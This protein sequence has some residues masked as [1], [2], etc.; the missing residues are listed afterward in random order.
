MRFELLGVLAALGLAFGFPVQEGP[1]DTDARCVGRYGTDMDGV[2]SSYKL[3][4]DDGLANDRYGQAVGIGEHYAVVGAPNKATP[5]DHC[6]GVVYIYRR[7]LDSWVLDG[8]IESPNPETGFFFG[9]SVAVYQSTIVIGKSR[10]SLKQ[11][12][13]SVYERDSTGTWVETA[14][15]TADDGAE[16]DRF[17]ISVS[18]DGDV[19]VIGAFGDDAE[20]A[21]NAG[22]AYVYEKASN[23]WS[24]SA[25][26][27]PSTTAQG[28]FGK[29]VDISGTTVL[30][31]APGLDN[32]G[33]AFFYS[34]AG[35]TWSL[36]E[37]VLAADGASGDKFGESVAVDDATA[38]IGA[39]GVSSG[40]G[41]AYVFRGTT[42]RILRGRNLGYLSWT[43]TSKLVAGDQDQMDLF[44]NVVDIH[45]S[46]IAVGAMYASPDGWCSGGA[47]LF[48]NTVGEIWVQTRMSA[49][50][51]TQ[52]DYLGISVAL[53]GNYMIAG[54]TGDDDMGS[55]S[56]SAYIYS[57]ATTIQGSC[58]AK[59]TQTQGGWFGAKKCRG[60]N[61][62]CYLLENFASAF[63]NGLVIGSSTRFAT[64]ATVEELW[65]LSKGGDAD[66]LPSSCDGGC[67]VAALSKKNNLITQTVALS[68]NVGFDSCSRGDCVSFCENCSGY[69]NPLLSAHVL[70]DMG[71]CTGMS[72]GQVLAEANCVLG[73]GSDCQEGI[74]DCIDYINNNYVDGLG[75]D[76]QGLSC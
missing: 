57:V 75:A 29:D 38:V 39:P 35:G 50:D 61:A 3:L 14:L 30:V 25:Q 6:Q 22:S 33:A 26:L 41:A 47:Y 11:G 18:I 1:L 13:A 74:I 21:S 36:V 51:N 60:N 67:T 66:S 68:L 72:V 52:R 76:A 54:A 27:A 59:R 42:S 56:G 20:G 69:N 10:A 58:L 24:L 64:I 62:A 49:A 32:K 73:G 5:A 28:H 34:K 7:V 4:A 31:G 2:L 55:H 65:Q 16:G 70:N 45:D 48:Q 17:G 15:L 71:G 63:P 43:Q 19:V 46:A 8:K 9:E 40:A 53:Y 12:A 23:V 44:G 37:T